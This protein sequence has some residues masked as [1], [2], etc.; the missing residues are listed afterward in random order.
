VITRVT[1]DV[2]RLLHYGTTPSNNCVE[3]C[4]L[5]VLTHDIVDWFVRSTMSLHLN[6]NDL[7]FTHVLTAMRGDGDTLDAE[8]VSYVTHNADPAALRQGVYVVTVNDQIVYIGKYDGTLARRW[9]YERAGIIYHHKRKAIANELRN[10]ADV[11]VYATKEA[12]VSTNNADVERAL[13]ASLKPAWNM[14]DAS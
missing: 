4:D 1:F 10:G 8:R 13:I 3:T 12:P 11:R 14:Q 6:I 5:H 2:Y 7:T 9:L